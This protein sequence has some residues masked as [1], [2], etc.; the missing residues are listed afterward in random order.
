MN[1]VLSTRVTVNRNLKDFKFSHKLTPEQKQQVVDLLTNILNG[2]MSLLNLS[3][4]DEKV[5]KH[6]LTNDLLLGGTQNLFVSKNANI[7][8]NLFTT[9]HISIVT[10]RVH[11]AT[12]K[13]SLAVILRSGCSQCYR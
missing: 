13:I 8:I 12:V 3:Q 10:T 11:L 5:V 7:A 2:K 1:N 6:L 9:E 4:A